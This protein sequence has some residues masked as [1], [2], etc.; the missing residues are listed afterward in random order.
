M[1]PA[2]QRFHARRRAVLSPDD[3][4]IMHL[5]SAGSERARD[6]A[7]DK[8][9]LLELRLHLRRIADDAPG[10]ALLGRAQRKIGAAR[11]LVAEHS[12]AWRD[13][14]TDCQADGNDL[15]FPERAAER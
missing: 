4:L 9:P 2:Q 6:L 15:V 5:E 1:M 11:E 7:L 10:A 13:C 8:S 12:I 3:R 14:K